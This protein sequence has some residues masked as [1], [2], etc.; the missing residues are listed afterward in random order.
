MTSGR[1]E[2][3]ARPVIVALATVMVAATE[4]SQRLGGV[5]AVVRN[6][7]AFALSVVGRFPSRLPWT[8]ANRPLRSGSSGER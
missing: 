2:D 6:S 8:G 4:V 3:F 7:P 1:S 5:R